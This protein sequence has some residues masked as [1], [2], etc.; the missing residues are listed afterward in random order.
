M[1]T[2]ISMGVV[3][4][5]LLFLETA[6]RLNCYNTSELGR[7]RKKYVDTRIVTDFA[8]TNG[9]ILLTNTT[10]KLTD[11][12]LQLMELFDGF[13][14]SPA[15]WRRV[16]VDY[17]NSYQPIWAKRIPAGRKEAFLFMSDEE[18]RCFLEAGLMKTPASQ[19][20]IKWWDA[21]AEKERKTKEGLSLQIGREGE[22]STIRYETKRTGHL[23]VWQSIETNIVGYDIISK[24][25][26]NN[27][28]RDILIEVKSSKQDINSAFMIIT[29]HE[30]EVANYRNNRHRYFFYI[31]LLGESNQMAKITVEEMSAHIPIEA[32]AGTWEKVR[33]PFSVFKCKFK[34]IGNIETP[35]EQI[36]N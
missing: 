17:I 16:L 11:S 31:W 20:I 10:F 26:E 27:D 9:W 13:S 12:G 4:E 2:Y 15:L 33:I 19:D 28:A 6:T 35:G 5:T 3:T 36:Y 14:I 18:K 7:L 8:S 22:E 32:G 30:W 21:I 25:T 34:K 29:R 24:E 1:N 23:P